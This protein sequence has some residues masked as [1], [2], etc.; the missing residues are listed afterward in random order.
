MNIAAARK[1]GLTRYTSTSPCLHGHTE[2][3]V[4]NHTCVACAREAT[5]RWKQAHP[6][7]D[8]HLKRQWVKKNPRKIRIYKRRHYLKLKAD[9]AGMTRVELALAE[10]ARAVKAAGF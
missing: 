1:R 10:L 2:R 7:V 3:Y 9:R 5:K 6:E 4:S 8:A